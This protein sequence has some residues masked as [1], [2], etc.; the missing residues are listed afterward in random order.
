MSGGTVV[1]GAGA[2]GLSAAIRLAAAGREVVVFEK[3][4]TTGGKIGEV[5]S[6]GYRW[7]TG[8]SVLTMLHVFRDLFRVA[9]R[10]LDGFVELIP[11]EPLAHYFFPDGKFVRLSRDLPTTL[12][13]IAKLDD[14]DVAGYLAFLSYA[15]R[16]HRLTGPVFIYGPPLTLRAFTQMSPWDGLR[17]DGFRTMERAIRG[18]VQSAHMR[19][20]LGRFATYVGASPYVAPATL[21]VIAHVEL[22]EGVWYPKGGMI[23]L[24]Q[25]LEKCAREVGVHIETGA[26]VG[27][28]E[29]SQGRVSGVVLASGKRVS[30]GSVISDVDVAHTC[31]QLLPDNILPRRKIRRLMDAESSC[32]GFAL[33]VGV[34]GKSENLAHHNIFFSEDYPREFAEI[35][36]QHI[37]QSNPTIYVSITSKSDPDHAPEGCENW[38]ILVNA[39]ALDGTIDW[40]ERKGAYAQLILKQLS[41]HGIDIRDRIE[42]MRII[43]PRDIERQ[44]AARL[45]ALYG[46]SSNSMF[47]A[48]RRPHNRSADVPGLYFA[49]GTV[50][51]GGGVPMAALSGKVA[52]DLLM[53]DGC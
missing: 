11:I 50:H 31:S 44:T 20:L 35:F 53:E 29:I 27:S 8:P 9:G 48:F 19:Q 40:E 49:G 12:S 13:E 30:A 2:G 5:I 16:L 47:A 36:N 45:G 14:R 3:N 23:R 38:F 7:D 32:S 4:A 6:D 22:N 33:L 10:S 25:A 26:K 34:R 41:A 51:P 1:I 21:N 46:S 24:A 28:L 39:P 18:F 52:S 17:I 37:P 42:A 15:A 43:T